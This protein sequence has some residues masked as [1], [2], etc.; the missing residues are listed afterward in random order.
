NVKIQLE[1]DGRL[2]FYC[3]NNFL[4]TTNTNNLSKGIGLTNV[5][6]RLQLLYPQKHELRIN[7]TDHL[8]EVHLHLQLV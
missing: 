3:K 7:K 1:E 8:Y 6:K 4:P 5:K 2:Y